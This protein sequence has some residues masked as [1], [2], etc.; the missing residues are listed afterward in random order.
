M[1]VRFVSSKHEVGDIHSLF[2]EPDKPLVWRAGEYINF[3][4]SG[5]PPAESERI[6]TIASAPHEKI[7]R[8][9]TQRGVSPFKDK[10]FS[11]QPGDQVEI[12]QLGGDFVWQDTPLPKLYIAG[13][14][15]ITPFRS[16]LVDRAH[17]QLPNRAFVMWAGTERQRPFDSELFDIAAHSTDIS[18]NSYDKMRI[19]KDL[20]YAEV[21]DIHSRLIYIAGSQKFVESI[22]ESLQKSGL[23]KNQIKYDWFDG[24]TDV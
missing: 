20:I 4:V 1:N 13:G 3:T 22:G 16:I 2:F 19:D 21:P 18:I 11:L 5:V 9:T 10:F 24:Y 6:F 23:P 14:L 7:L 17:K 12:D 15:G 8:I